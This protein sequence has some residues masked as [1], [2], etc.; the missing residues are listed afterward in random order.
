MSKKQTFSSSFCIGCKKDFLNS[1]ALY[2]HLNHIKF[3]CVQTYMKVFHDPINNDSCNVSVSNSENLDQSLIFD[4]FE[5]E[6]IHNTIVNYHIGNKTIVQKTKI[7]GNG[8][9]N[10]CHIH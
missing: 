2:L 8:L 7:I 4:V 6:E 1:K 3:N 5:N 9:N 10:L